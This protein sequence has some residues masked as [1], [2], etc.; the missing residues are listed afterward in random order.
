MV[1]HAVRVRVADRV[2][3]ELG[4]VLED[5]VQAPVPALG[6]RLDLGR[7]DV[8]ADRARNLEELLDRL[9]GSVGLGVGRAGLEFP[10]DDAGVRAGVGR[11]CLTE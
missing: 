2:L 6:A 1:A 11:G 10:E 7:A 8:H 4:A 3:V 9:L 5:R